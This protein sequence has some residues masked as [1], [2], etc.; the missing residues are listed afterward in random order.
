MQ[1]DPLVRLERAARALRDADD[2]EEPTGR[3]DVHVHLDS[4]PDSDRPAPKS[5][6]GWVKLV[7][8][9]LGTGLVAGLGALLQQ[10]GQHHP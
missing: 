5:L 1:S 7:L 6:A 9:A 2:W 10:C 4:K 3:T 8:V